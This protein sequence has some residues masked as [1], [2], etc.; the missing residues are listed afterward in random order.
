MKKS[1]SVV[2][3]E[4]AN[5]SSSEKVIVNQEIMRLSDEYPSFR[6]VYSTR[7]PNRKNPIPG[8][9][10]GWGYSQ[11][12]A[13]V[14]EYDDDAD[15]FFTCMDCTELEKY[16]IQFRLEEEAIYSR[17]PRF[18]GVKWHKVNHSLVYGDDGRIFDRETVEVMVFTLEDWEALKKDWQ[19]HNGYKDDESGRLRHNQM[20]E[21]RFIH[22]TEVFWFDVTKCL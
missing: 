18:P 7:F 17:G 22:F 5:K 20:R 21:T 14:I 3:L 13:A 10:G 6:D 9:Y 19:D 1:D 2:S 15:A 11:E 4:D 12:D 16:F 8:I